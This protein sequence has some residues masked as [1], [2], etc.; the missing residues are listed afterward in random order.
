MHVD[1]AVVRALLAAQCPQLAGGALR[2]V[3]EGWDNVTYL[4]ADEHAVRLPR[5]EAAVALLLHEL[6]WLP[7]LADGLELEVPL[8][9]HRGEPDDA[10][11]WPWSVVRWVRGDS[12]ELHVFSAEDAAL[13]ASTLRHLH[14][15][16]PAEA[17]GNPF[18]GVPLRTRADAV[19]ERL[20]RW[21]GSSTWRW[22]GCV[23]SGTTPWPRRRR[24]SAAGCTATSTPAT[25]SCGVAVSPA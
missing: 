17:P 13:L 20:E 7:E 15:P 14:R 25:W 22:R 11:P 9:V 8:P 19:E 3:D 1:D 4:L 24:R 2:R 21:A 12:A 16:A 18:R 6:R 23:P 10:F 5:R